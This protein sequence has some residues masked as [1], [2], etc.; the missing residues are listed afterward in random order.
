LEGLER[1]QVRSRE[2]GPRRRIDWKRK[3]SL[4]RHLFTVGKSLGMHHIQTTIVIGSVRGVGRGKGPED[5]IMG[6]GQKKRG[7]EG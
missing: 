7:A 5:W 1:G 2:P 3:K 4:I 6:G